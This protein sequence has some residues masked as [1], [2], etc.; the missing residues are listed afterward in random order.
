MRPT[1]PRSSF[2]ISARTQTICVRQLRC[3]R[4]CRGSR[5]GQ[6]L[7][8][9]RCR[10][11]AWKLRWPTGR[12]RTQL[13]WRES[14]AQANFRRWCPSIGSTIRAWAWAWIARKIR[15][16][17]SGRRTPNSNTVRVIED[18]RTLL[19]AT[20]GTQ[21]HRLIVPNHH[22]DNTIHNLPVRED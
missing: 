14:T 8:S 7:R 9:K 1:W 20:V 6:E 15:R 21:G 11:S 12:A 17:D 5:T 10:Q 19:R 13:I 22:L 2:R 18:T 4:R 16:R 3:L